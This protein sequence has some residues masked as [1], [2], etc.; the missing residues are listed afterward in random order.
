[1]KDIKT[2]LES[3]QDDLEDMTQDLLDWLDQNVTEDGY[4]NRREYREDLETFLDD[5][6]DAFIDDALD[7]L[8]DGAGWNDKDIDRHYEALIAVMKRWA[9][10]AL[11]EI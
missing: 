11:D 1:M 5:Q 2:F 9:K 8:V 3:A 6:N 7:Y 4:N 10:D